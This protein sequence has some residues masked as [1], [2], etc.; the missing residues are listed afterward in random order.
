MGST[1]DTKYVGSVRKEEVVVAVASCSLDRFSVPGFPAG[2]RRP[3][4]R[5]LTASS[6][7]IPEVGDP[8]LSGLLPCERPR[9]PSSP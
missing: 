8:L 7:F 4:R 6:I 3:Y 9:G 5:F 1:V 2:I